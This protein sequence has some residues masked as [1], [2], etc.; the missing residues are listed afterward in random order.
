MCGRWSE[1]FRQNEPRTPADSGVRDRPGRSR[2]RP[3][4]ALPEAWRERVPACTE[5]SQQMDG[6][7]GA[8]RHVC[9]GSFTSK[10]APPAYHHRAADDA[11]DLGSRR[12]AELTGPPRPGARRSV[13]QIKQ[14]GGDVFY[15]Y[16]YSL[17]RSSWAPAWLRR[18]E[19][20]SVSYYLPAGVPA[21]G[22]PAQSGEGVSI[23]TF[24][25]P[26]ANP[27]TLPP[28]T[29][30]MSVSVSSLNGVKSPALPPFEDIDTLTMSQ[31][32]SA[33]FS[34]SFFDEDMAPVTT[35][36]LLDS[37]PIK[38]DDAV[39]IAKL[40]TDLLTGAHAPIGSPKLNRAMP[41]HGGND[42]SDATPFHRRGSPPGCND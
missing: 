32:E 24:Q 26:G 8:T 36:L 3:A 7:G 10:V 1:E 17:A 16:A 15:D 2:L 39:E 12:R 40:K 20:T 6:Q 29:M 23:R 25:F 31:I 4:I 14:A 30:S 41:A 5:V 21:G 38:K 18:L 11:R 28:I 34:A 33:R 9:T 22:H 13:A 42:W 37:A 35:A 19:T 27:N